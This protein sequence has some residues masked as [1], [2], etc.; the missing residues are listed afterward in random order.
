MF[1]EGWQSDRKIRKLGELARR[2]A[3]WSKAG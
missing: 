2:S 1:N 3:K